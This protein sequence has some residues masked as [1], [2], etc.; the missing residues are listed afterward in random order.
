MNKS[1]KIWFITGIV[2]LTVISGRLFLPLSGIGPVFPIPIFLWLALYIISIGAIIII[3]VIY[4]I[5]FWFVSGTPHPEGNI[6]AITTFLALLDVL[7]FYSA[8]GDG[9]RVQGPI[10]TK[11]V[12]VENLFG[13]IFVYLFAFVGIFKKSR[14]FLYVSNLLLFILLAWCAFPFLG[15]V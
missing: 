12:A 13:F 1:D 10:Y 3:P 5:E 6:L 14:L 7:Y 11:V 9:I 4:A 2:L 15:G 8:W